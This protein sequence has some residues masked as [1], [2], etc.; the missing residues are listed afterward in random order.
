MMVDG[1]EVTGACGSGAR[2]GRQ[3]Q[4]RHHQKGQKHSH[5]GL[6]IHLRAGATVDRWCRCYASA[7]RASKIRAAAD[8]E[9]GD[10]PAN[11]GAVASNQQR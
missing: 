5:S 4:Q 2:R 7:A 9:D 8:D 11:T 10:R 6:Q 1:G 3:K